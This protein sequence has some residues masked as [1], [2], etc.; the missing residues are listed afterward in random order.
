[1]KNDYETYDK[2]AGGASY[3]WL[4]R[5]IAINKPNN[6]I[7]DLWLLEQRIDV[8]LNMLLATPKESWE[9]C[10]KTLEDEIFPAAILAFHSLDAVKIGQVVDAGLVFTQGF[11]CLVSALGWLPGRLCHPWIRNWFNGNNLNY[12]YLAIAACSAR[13]EDPRE[14][15]ADIFQNGNCRTHNKLYARALR[16]VGELKRH[17]LAG[18][19]RTAMQ[20]DSP[21]IVF[22][23][24]WSA[25]MLGNRFWAKHL[26]PFALNRGHHQADAIALVFRALPLQWAWEWIDEML[27][28]PDNIRSAIQSVATLGDP[29]AIDWLIEQMRIPALTRLAGEAFTT[30]T[31]IDLDQHQL[32]LDDLP[33]L[34]DHVP[35]EN[36]SGANTHSDHYLPFPNVDK[37]AAVWQIY[38]NR[39]VPGRRYLMGQPLSEEHLTEV[40]SIANQR[41]RRA[42]ALEL[43]LLMHSQVLLNYAAKGLTEQFV[44]APRNAF[45]E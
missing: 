6:N 8:Q 24:S 4:L 21:E 31:G 1:M 9:I 45:S 39:F 16:L 38:H 11:K 18:E 17:D 12:K 15:L 2:L 42:A 22:W 27:K 33:N 25:V 28:K 43:S 34:D 5:S 32:S 29:H 36:S 40:Y 26:Q 10:E 37:V 44:R 30:I 13:R 19:L 14:H 41:Q 7:S 23:A 35:S 3:L 20:S